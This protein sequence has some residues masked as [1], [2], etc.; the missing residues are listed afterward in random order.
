MKIKRI[1][2]D[3]FKLSYH[4][5]WDY[6]YVDNYIHTFYQDDGI[7]ALQISSYISNSHDLV[8]DIYKEKL[9]YDNSTIKDYLNFQAIHCVE[10]KTNSDYIILKWIIGKENRMIFCTYSVSIDDVHSDKYQ[11]EINEIEKIIN[12]IEIK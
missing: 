1:E 2:T 5:N 6:D 7:G 9:K 8:F 10:Y 3:T 11:N 4:S 12:T